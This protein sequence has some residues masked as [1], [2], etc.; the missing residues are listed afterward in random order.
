[1]KI[2]S[3]NEYIKCIHTLRLN[4]V[5]QLA[6]ESSNYNLNNKNVHNE[7]DKLIKNVLKNK[8]EISN[9]INEYLDLKDL[10]KQSDLI[11]YTNSY[12]NKKYKSKEADV[13]YKLKNKEIYFLIEHQ[14]YVDNR[15]PYRILNYCIDI[16]QEWI[17]SKRD[18]NIIHYPI[19][20]PIVIYTGSKKWKVPVNFK[21]K[22]ISTLVFE[23]YKINLEY[24]LMDINKLSKED[25]MKSN[26]MFGYAM[27]IEK[28]KNKQELKENIDLIIR[29]AKNKEMLEE[30][31]DI[32]IYILNGILEETEQEDLLNKINKKV[33]EGSMSTL[34]ER[35]LEET[36][37]TLKQGELKGE[38]KGRKEGLREGLRE[39]VREVIKNMLS[40]NFDDKTI[41]KATNMSEKEL[42]EIKR[43]LKT[44]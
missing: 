8:T 26:T 5:L 44:V 2:F 32:V 41:M 6:E 16:M 25:L 18:K 31:A 34:Y 43:S 19:I 4:A 3:Y 1:M 22:Q 15:M 36:K 11:K 7:H 20:V 29:S 21:D 17:K 12:I 28:S 42:Q 30:L 10:V 40:M 24:N 14:S 9:I 23:R 38:K 13:V 27:V 33:G 37:R 35:L 39:G